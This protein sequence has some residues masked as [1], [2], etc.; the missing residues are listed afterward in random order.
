MPTFQ[1]LCFDHRGMGL[2]TPATAAT[3]TARGSPEDQARYL[4]HFRA[5]NAV[6]DLE[7][8]RKCLAGAEKWSIMGTSYGGFVCLN[9]LSYYPEGLREAFPVAG[10]APITQAVPDRAIEKL[11]HKVVERNQI[12]Y[13]KYPEDEQNVRKIVGWIT[14]TEPFLPCGDLLTAGRFLEMGI[15]LGFHRGLDQIHGVVLRAANDI[16]TVGVLTRP[17]LSI[18]QN[19]SAFADH[20]LYAVLHTSIYVQGRA[21]ASDW[22]FDRTLTKFPQFT[23][24]T[25]D[26]NP[27]FFTGEMVFRRAFDDYE[28]LKPLLAA[29]ELLEKSGWDGLYDLEQLRRNDV[30]V[31]A[32]IFVDDMY[33]DF[34]F[35]RETASL[36]Q[37]CKTFISNLLYHDAMRAGKCE[38]VLKALFALRDDTID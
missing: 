38:D 25:D 36:V 16:D 22:V 18:I 2:S 29:T 23:P 14:N 12:Y 3:I 19:M 13:A 37:G 30:P 26:Q 32:A 10:M 6:R 24:N 15:V 33:V 21:N 1:L 7:A 8:I 28:E 5:D 27:I 20:P 4:R 17:T 9:Y 11:F 34:D 31:Y 35:S